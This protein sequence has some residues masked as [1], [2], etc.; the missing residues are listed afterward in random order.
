MRTSNTLLGIEWGSDAEDTLAR[1]AFVGGS[2]RPWPGNG[3]FEVFSSSEAPVKVFGEA[4]DLH[5]I[6]HGAAIE[7]VQ[8]VFRQ[9]GNCQRIAIKVRRQFDLTDDGA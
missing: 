3:G 4:A 5:F 7:G 6:R 9:S 2:W 1:L 8:A